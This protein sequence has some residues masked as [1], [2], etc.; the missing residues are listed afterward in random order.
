MAEFTEVITK[1]VDYPDCA[2]NRVVKV[3]K[4]NGQQRY[5]C[6]A[7]DKKFRANGIPEGRQAPAEQ[8]GMAIRMFYSG[9]S[10]KQIA[11]TTADA[12]NIPEPSKS[13]LYEW[14]CE[15]TDRAVETMRQ[16]EYRAVTRPEWVADEMQVTVGGQ[17]Y[18]NWNVMDAKTR[19]I[20]ASHLSRS[21]GLGSR[22][23]RDGTGCRRCH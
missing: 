21:P 15:Y 2:S 10:Y 22:R 6:R 4:Q 12:F 11:E 5:L 18:W 17:K 7:C 19:F 20:R 14:V 13:T 1:T 16:P 23:N 8:M 3:G 9:M